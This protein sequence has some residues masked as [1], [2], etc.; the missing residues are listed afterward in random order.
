[1]KKINLLL[2]V[3][4]VTILISCGGKSNKKE[5]AGVTSGTDK[6]EVKVSDCNCSELDG[7]GN[8]SGITDLIEVDEISGKAI[9][10]IGSKDLFTGSCLDKDQYD[11]IIRKVD[12][13]NGWKIKSIYKEKINNEYIQTGYFEYENGNL[14]NNWSLKFKDYDGPDL[15]LK[16]TTEYKEDKKNNIINQWYIS[17]GEFN[18]ISI[19]GV[20]KYKDGKPASDSELSMSILDKNDISPE[21]RDKLLANLKKELPHFNYWKIK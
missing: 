10:K 20:N 13:K 3:M 5:E 8:Y 6:K 18:G 7:V 14:V 1:M 2:G 19:N 4:L 21:E 16:Y 17:L 15:K 9:T 11:S 12:F